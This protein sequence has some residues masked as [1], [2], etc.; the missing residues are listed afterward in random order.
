LPPH[1]EHDHRILLKP[2]AVPA[3]VK[4]Y[5]YPALQKDVIESAVREMLHFSVVRPSHSLVLLPFCW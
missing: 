4:P 3:N 2:G 5:R 1:R